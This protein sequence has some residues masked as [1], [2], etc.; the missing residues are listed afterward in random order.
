[1]STSGR[2]ATEDREVGTWITYYIW[3]P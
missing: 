1:M 3:L 2:W